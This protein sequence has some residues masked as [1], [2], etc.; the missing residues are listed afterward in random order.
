M[1]SIIDFLETAFGRAI[2]FGALYGLVFLFQVAKLDL[3][4]RDAITFLSVCGAWAVI[5]IVS[6]LN[7]GKTLAF[8]AS[9]VIAWVTFQ[10][11]LPQTS[12]ALR[13]KV[14]VID[15]NAGEAIRQVDQAGAE[16]MMTTVPTPQPVAPQPR[17][18]PATTPL[19]EPEVPVLDDSFKPIIER[20]RNTLSDDGFKPITRKKQ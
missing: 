10:G 20:S 18:I 14:Q 16:L 3:L 19:S 12:E 5:W 1:S 7:S 2:G 15:R 13:T 4:H 8:I 17:A 6:V 11:F 9:L